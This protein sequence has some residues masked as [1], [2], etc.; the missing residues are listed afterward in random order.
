M[1]LTLR[2][3]EEGTA[4]AWAGRWRPTMATRAEQFRDQQER[5]GSKA[6]AKK[7][8]KPKK[9]AWSR[10]KHHAEVKATRALEDS[11]PRRRPSRSSTRASS[12]RAKPDAPFNITEE[13]RKNAP[14]ARAGKARAKATKVRGSR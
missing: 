7:K 14:R 12:N 13:E 5:K 11:A 4:L 10:E 2:S 3:R 8:R 1:G 9:A 6:P